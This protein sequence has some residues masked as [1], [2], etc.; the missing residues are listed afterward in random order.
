MMSLF[1]SRDFGAVEVSGRI[2]FSLVYYGQKE[3]L[4]VKVHCCEDIASVR[5]SRSNP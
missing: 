4:H 3:E 1:S 5:K 2:Q